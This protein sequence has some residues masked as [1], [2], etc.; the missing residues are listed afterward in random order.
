M[1]ELRSTGWLYL[2]YGTRRTNIPQ[3]VPN[4]SDIIWK[5]LEISLLPQGALAQ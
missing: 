1:F 2:L 3:N 5:V 4:Q